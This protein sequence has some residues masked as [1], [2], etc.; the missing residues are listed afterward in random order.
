ME[1]VWFA[2]FFIFSLRGDYEVMDSSA[3]GSHYKQSSGDLVK[4]KSVRK[5]EKDLM[6]VCFLKH[7]SSALVKRIGVH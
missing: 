4:K 5:G 1:T 3:E 6:Y 2:W 7:C